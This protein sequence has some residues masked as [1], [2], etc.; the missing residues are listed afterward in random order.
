MGKEVTKENTEPRSLCVQPSL[1]AQL[2]D[3]K[4]ERW[5]RWVNGG[6]QSELVSCLHG[7]AVCALLISA[8]PREAVTNG[9]RNENALRIHHCADSPQRLQSLGR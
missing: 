2:K 8:G 4:S 5:V 6:L 1:I 3:G 7:S 9:K